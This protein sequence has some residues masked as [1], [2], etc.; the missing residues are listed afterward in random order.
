M[1]TVALSILAA[2]LFVVF[3]M[4]LG[5]AYLII[6]ACW[7]ASGSPDVNGDPERDAGA[8]STPPEH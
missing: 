8:P 1:T 6:G 2:V 4:V 5:A 7:A 3:S